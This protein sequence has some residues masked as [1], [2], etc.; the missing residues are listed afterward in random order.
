M[1]N[2][3]PATNGFLEIPLENL[4]HVSTEDT[5]VEMEEG[6]LYDP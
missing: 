3:R 4:T 5:E 2:P 6:G 1:V